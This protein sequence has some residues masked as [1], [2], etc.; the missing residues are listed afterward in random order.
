MIITEFDGHAFSPN[1]VATLMGKS[2]RGLPASKARM[3]TRRGRWPLIGGIDREGRE[4]YLGIS[5]EGSDVDALYAQL[6]Q[7]LDPESETVKKLTVTDDDGSDERYVEVACEDLVQQDD[8]IK[9]IYVATLAVHDDVRWRA[10]TPTTHTWGITGSGQTGTIVNSGT[11][12]AYP[13]FKITAAAKTGGFVYKCWVP[14][15]WN[16]INPATD[17]PLMATL[18]TATLTTAKMQADGDDLRVYADG[19]EIYRW[20]DAMDTA[21]TKI[22]FYLSFAASQSFTLKTYIADAG[23]IAQIDSNEDITRFPSTGTLLIGTEAF[24]YTSKDNARK[25]FLGITR[26]AKGTSL[27]AHNVGATG[28][29]I[30]H[31]VWI[32]YGN[33]ALTAPTVNDD[34]KPAFELDHSTNASWVYEVFGDYNSKR[35]GRWEPNSS[36]FVMQTGEPWTYLYGGAYS[37]TG[38]ALASPFTVMGA[39]L[40]SE[41][42]AYVEWALH[43]PCGITNAAWSNGLKRRLST[44]WEATTVYWLR[45][46]T[47][48]WW[49]TQYAIPTPSVASAWE[50]WSY[51]GAAFGVSDKVGF[52]LWWHPCDVEV[53]DVTVTL[54]AAEIPTAAVY[55]EQSTYTMNATLTNVTTGDAIQVAFE[56]EANETLQIDT[57]AKD[58]TYLKDGSSQFQAVTTLGTVRQDW[59]A[60]LPGTSVLMLEDAGITGGTIVTSFRQRYY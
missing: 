32:M 12:R 11:E 14:I 54:N 34:Y 26:G 46:Q 47:A 30:Q 43:N 13:T 4:L 35:T 28:Y 24:V 40:G 33:A 19:R 21:A 48:Y 39:W 38:R 36:L 8:G 53:G 50:A 5:I 15:V 31:D 20:L 22:W 9:T 45:V 58:V 41:R 25:L 60:L 7:W 17:Y 23:N 57:W 10:E 42:S 27:A 49:Q 29:W 55:A 16:S 37:Q 2:M 56:L 52:I 3:I 1:F 44:T 6:C 18:D 59:L 51:S